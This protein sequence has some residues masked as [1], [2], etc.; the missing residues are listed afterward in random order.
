M[1]RAQWVLLA[2]EAMILFGCDGSP[3]DRSEGPVPQIIHTA[4]ALPAISSAEMTGTDI[5]PHFD[6]PLR[7]GRN[8]VWCASLQLA[9][10][11]A[12]E[13]LGAPLGLYPSSDLIRRLNR[14]DVTARHVNPEHVVIGAGRRDQGVLR[15]IRGEIARKFPQIGELP[16]LGELQSLPGEAYIMYALLKADLPFP[17]AFDDLPALR[18]YA[19][20]RPAP[21]EEDDG[22]D[23]ACFGI[24]QARGRRA[25][26]QV[27]IIWHTFE[28][29]F[30][31]KSDEPGTIREWF[32]VELQT[33]SDRD[34]LILAKI[35]SAGTL[36]RAVEE[37]MVKLDTPNPIGVPLVDPTDALKEQ[38][39]D[40]TLTELERMLLWRRITDAASEVGRLRV[41]ETLRIP[42]V[43]VHVTHD[44]EELRGRHADNQEIDA[45]MVLASQ[46]IAFRLDRTGASVESEAADAA[47]GMGDR[48]FTFDEPFLIMLIREGAMLPYFAMWVGNT[49][50]MAEGTH[51]RPD[52]FSSTQAD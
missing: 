1:L 9:W 23:V 3:L 18:F 16:L 51:F 2:L 48:W 44:F 41:I 10:N 49:E 27:H 30:S 11:A 35:P 25:E 21:G 22:E 32:V 20:G 5:A 31:D 17:T 38:L 36:W 52:F 29:V 33:V 19:N 7:P 45:P 26:E 8:V 39:R 43:N 14:G 42:V 28:P 50:S 37:V 24:E 40:P 34:R 15:H 12:L 6:Y 13:D 47:V 46:R 4:P